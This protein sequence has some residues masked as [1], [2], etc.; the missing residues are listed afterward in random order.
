MGVDDITDVRTL[1]EALKQLNQSQIDELE[2]SLNLF[3]YEG[4]VV[5]DVA[6]DVVEDEVD[7]VALVH[8]EPEVESAAVD[9]DETEPTKGEP[10]KEAVI[11]SG[12]AEAAETVDAEVESAKVESNHRVGGLAEQQGEMITEQ[13]Q[14]LQQQQQQQQQHLQEVVECAAEAAQVQEVVHKLV[15]PVEEPAPAPEEPAAPAERQ[16]PKMIPL[17]SCD[18]HKKAKKNPRRRFE[19]LDE[20][21]DGMTD[22]SDDSCS[23]D[24]NFTGDD[25][26]D[27]SSLSSGSSDDEK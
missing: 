17:K 19:S 25:L 7:D 8:E 22:D 20:S 16:T 1:E 4:A 18:G 9:V 27:V 5:D 23:Y 11:E 15:E 12:V 6:D 26:S 13:N 10:L 14:Q 24:G 21:S 2:Q 3:G